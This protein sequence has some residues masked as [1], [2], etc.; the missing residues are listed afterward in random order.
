MLNRSKQL[1]E[2]SIA[3]ID[4]TR[5]NLVA[6]AILDHCVTQAKAAHACGDYARAA[7]EWEI[8]QGCVE[9]MREACDDLATRK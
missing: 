4:A 8:V 6:F 3:D 9:G 5:K 1:V 7:Q 2:G